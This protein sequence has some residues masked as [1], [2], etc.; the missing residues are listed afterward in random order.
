[1]VCVVCL[2]EQLNLDTVD[3]I[4]VV[5]AAGCVLHQEATLLTVQAPVVVRESGV[6]VLCVW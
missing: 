2:Q 3:L 6:Y 1:M 4:D 5:E